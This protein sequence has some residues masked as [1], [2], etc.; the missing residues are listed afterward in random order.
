VTKDAIKVG[1]AII[2]YDAI[3]NFVDYER[4]DQE[5]TA[6]V[7]VDAINGAGGINGRKIVPYFKKYPP[8][9]VARPAR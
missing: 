9:P 8:I 3:S 7:F 6:R 5:A 1:F 4:G 2:D